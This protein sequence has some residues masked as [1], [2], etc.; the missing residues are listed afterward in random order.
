MQRV[1][2]S[3]PG[4][5][6][7]RRRRALVA[8]LAMV[9]APVTG[10]VVL[11]SAPGASAQLRDPMTISADKEV[12]AT[13]PGIPG[14][15][16][17]SQE[18]D[19]TP[20][21]CGDVAEASTLTAACDVIPIKI[22][23]PNVGEA[24][25]FIVELR[26]TWDPADQV[27]DVGA[28]NDLD[29]YLYDNKQVAQRD[30]PESTTYTQ[31]GKSANATPPETIRLYRPEL[32][33]YNIVVNNFSGPNISY[34]IAARILIGRFQAPFEALAPNG[35][36]GAPVDDSS[37]DGSGPVDFSAETP[38]ATG[39]SAPPA[40][41]STPVLGE[42]AVLPDQDFS[43]FGTGSSFDDQLRTP[44][45]AVTAGVVSLRPPKAVPAAVLLFWFLIA[46]LA[47]LGPVLFFVTRRNRT[48]TR[49][50]VS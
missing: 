48:S 45:N 25:D 10:A 37:G 20:A 4:E 2:R 33:D 34:K 24:D 9:A 30:D 46:P 8:L 32:G 41:I 1:Q 11:A 14:N 40:A 28:V 39:F 36:V 21:D 22:I 38:T 5:P 47:V 29:M 23:T 6:G 35:S 16:P 43:E 17:G 44:V 13:F 12:T 3:D 31:F 50:P 27:Q 7:M 15:N 26:L 19:P 18:V 42:V 49:L